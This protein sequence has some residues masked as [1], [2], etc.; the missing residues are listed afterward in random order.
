MIEEKAR[1]R[2]TSDKD[3]IPNLRANRESRFNFLKIF[4]SPKTYDFENCR[5]K[6]RRISIE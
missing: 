3:M 5:L 1:A 6:M 4:S 2:K